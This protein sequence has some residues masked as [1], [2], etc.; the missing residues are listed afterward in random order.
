V[1]VKEL[2]AVGWQLADQLYT[3]LVGAGPEFSQA[4]VVAYLNS[5]T[6]YSDNGFLFPIN[7]T[8]GHIDPITHPEVRGDEECANFLKVQGGKF[9]PVYGEPDKP[10]VCLQT[11]DPGVENATRKSFVP[12]GS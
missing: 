7:W 5:L 11:K 12:A 6:D 4:K 3:G 9:V 10:W 8:T 1:E 2:T